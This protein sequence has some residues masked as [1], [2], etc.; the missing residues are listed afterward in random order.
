MKR[1]LSIFLLLSSVCHA[2]NYQ[3]LQSGIKHYFINGNNYL[4]GI[5]IDSVKTMGDT[6]VYYPY[7]TMRNYSDTGGSWLGNKVLQLSDGTFLFDDIWGDT[8]TIKTQAHPGDEWLFYNDTIYHTYVATVASVDTMTI[9]GAIDS[10]KKIVIKSYHAGLLD[11]ID[12][13]INNF[14]IILSKNNGFIE[15][16][17]LY[18]FPYYSPSL[19]TYSSGYDMYLDYIS[20][21]YPDA[22]NSEFMMVQYHNPTSLEMYN[23]DVGDMF[24]GHYSTYSMYCPL[25]RLL[26]YTHYDSVI[27][28]TIVD[29]FHVNYA[30][31]HILYGTDTYCDTCHPFLYTQEYIDTLHTDTS[32]IFLT[33]MPEEN[34]IPYMAYYFYPSDT[35]FCHLS[36]AYKST[37]INMYE[38]CPL[39]ADFKQGFLPTYDS[40]TCPVIP[41]AASSIPYDEE[42]TDIMFYALV[43]DSSCGNV[44]LPRLKTTTVPAANTIAI[45]PNPATTV[46][47]IGSSYLPITKITISNLLGQTVYSE[48]CSASD[49]EVD[50]ANFP[51][52]IYIVRINNSEVRKFVKE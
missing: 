11:S 16:F 47:M 31:H 12:D 32:L 1:I 33:Q 21:Y 45:F 24:A 44:I 10:V 36:P 42:V 15:V 13:P 30:I 43:N 50:I 25:A 38:G 9:R 4:R 29:S 41:C 2:Q 35:S 52:G 18:T 39:E 14:N 27:N 28:K 5:S 46:L 6:T 49:I 26:D 17:D 34:T 37:E 48:R 20:G 51:P 7:K 8:V 22:G 3:C 19:G 40:T 23:F